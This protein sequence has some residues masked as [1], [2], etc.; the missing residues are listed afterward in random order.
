MP[1]M[2]RLRAMTQSDK[3]IASESSNGIV[4][5][6]IYYSDCIEQKMYTS[7]SVGLKNVPLRKP[8]FSTRNSLSTNNQWYFTS[9]GLLLVTR[10]LRV[11]SVSFRMQPK[12]TW[13]MASTTRSS[14]ILSR[15]VKLKRVVGWGDSP[16]PPPTRK[17]AKAG[18]QLA[19]QSKISKNQNYSK[20]SQKALAISYYR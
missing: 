13:K 7:N 16:A 14:V 15:P 8:I 3:W 2:F 1:K 4:N 17:N 10:T 19:G 6:I 18:P 5:F 11:T 12:S 20:K 9:I